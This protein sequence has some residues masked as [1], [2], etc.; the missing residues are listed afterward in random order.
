MNLQVS[1]L[2]HPLA[3][4]L[5]TQLR[6][7][8]TNGES[9]RAI[10]KRLG[11]LLVSQ[12]TS[13]LTVSQISVQTPLE[14][15]SGYKLDSNP[16]FIPILRAGL[17]LLPAAQE[18]FPN[19]PVGFIGVARDEKTAIPHSYLCKT[20]DPTGR[21]VFILDPM[22]ATGGSVVMTM[23]EIVKLGMPKSLNLVHVI[24]SPEGI[25]RV[26]KEEFPVP[27]TLTI[28]QIDRQLDDH[29]YILP[30]LGDYGDRLFSE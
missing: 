24:A 22:L 2:I 15:T 17:G 8:T 4:Q 26:A 11:L 3:K 1:S 30:G 29:K 18:L 10:S 12:A 21:D 28:A 14:V 5:L 16:L 23:H 20:M 19:S 13:Q 7:V 9:Y 27:V 6:D 25:N